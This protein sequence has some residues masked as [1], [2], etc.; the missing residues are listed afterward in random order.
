MS[1]K[2]WTGND[3]WGGDEAFCPQCGSVKVGPITLS[4]THNQSDLPMGD[5][6][7]E[8]WRDIT[9]VGLRCANCDLQYFIDDVEGIVEK[10]REYLQGYID[11]IRG[12]T[13]R[14]GVYP[15][16]VRIKHHDTHTTELRGPLLNYVVKKGEVQV[17]RHPEAEYTYCLTCEEVVK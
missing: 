3:K 15:R 2:K 8:D 9:P 12:G 11:E 4:E 5:R 7:V 17:G 14:G 6:G 13:Q 16:K 10:V 1:K